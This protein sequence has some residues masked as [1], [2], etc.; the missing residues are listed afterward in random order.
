VRVQL[1]TIFRGGRLAQTKKSV[2]KFISSLDSDARIAHATILVN[3]A[4]IIALVK[5][6]AIDK[7]DAEKILKA[8]G[9]SEKNIKF[10]E[11]VEDIHVLIEEYVTKR[12]GK[13]IGGQMHLGKSRNDQVVTAI[14]IALRQEI[15][16][17]AKLLISLEN[18]LL[19][20]AS[21]H[22]EA[23]FPGYTHLQ[24]AQPIT[25]AHYL[26]ALGDA[27][28][29]DIDRAKQTYE[30][31]NKSPMGAAAIAGTSFNLNRNSV[32][33]LLGFEGLVENSLDAVGTRDF[34]VETLS[35]CAITSLDISRLAQ[36]LIFYS[37]DDVG[38]IEIPDEFTSTSSIMPQKKNPDPL[39]V[40]RARCAQVIGNFVSAATTVH[41][42]PSG[43]NL[44]FQ[45]LTPLL[46][47]SIDLIKSC[48]KLLCELIPQIRMNKEI[49]NRDNLRFITATEIANVLVLEEKLPFRTAH[50]AVGRA[51]KMTLGGDLSELTREKWKLILGKDV[52]EQTFRRINETHNLHMSPRVYRTIG[53]PNPKQT[54]L[55]ISKR[56][57]QVRELTEA[58]NSYSKKSNR[59]ILRL[60]AKNLL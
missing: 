29:R 14:R 37:S 42:L 59:S 45:E 57:Q 28:L 35:V 2:V 18:K 10:R 21:K 44:D 3:K 40:M 55:M 41:A 36:D 13:Q 50:Q 8:L 46:W 16:E 39:E 33:T 12:T 34:A 52:K 54:K 49:A 11:N 53:S 48:L 1:S 43:F 22:T 51:V 26:E 4:H 58:I 31:V 24:P 30:R 60:Q 56:K 7:Q 6:K 5:A 23:M 47:N 17:V 32:G 38:L 20:V 25:F 19:Q 27:F 9:E 15:L